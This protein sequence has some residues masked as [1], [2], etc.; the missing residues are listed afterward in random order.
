[1]KRGFL[2]LGLLMMAGCAQQQSSQ[3]GTVIPSAP[4]VA[5]IL[6]SY[7]YKTLSSV[8]CYAQPLVGEER[9]L[10][11]YQGPPPPGFGWAGSG[12]GNR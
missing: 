9:R 3:L 6:P 5:P 8:D 11:N 10:V 4:Y 1:M 12:S 2:V 7:C